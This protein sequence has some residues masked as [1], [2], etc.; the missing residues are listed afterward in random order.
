MANQKN[1]AR[2]VAPAILAPRPAVT[3]PLDFAKLAEQAETTEAEVL[4][5]FLKLC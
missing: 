1:T 4:E 3:S 5:I 2:K